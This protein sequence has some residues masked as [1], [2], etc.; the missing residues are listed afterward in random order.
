[1]YHKFKL[2]KNSFINDVSHI[3]I[4]IEYLIKLEIVRNYYGQF[5][6]LTRFE[7]DIN[8]DVDIKNYIKDN[9][10]NINFGKDNVAYTLNTIE[11]LNKF[12]EFF[13]LLKEKYFANSS[14][15]IVDIEKK[16]NLK[17]E[18]RI[19]FKD[20]IDNI[21]LL[22][23]NKPKDILDL[24]I[25]MENIE[26]IFVII[27]KDIYKDEEFNDLINLLIMELING[28][29][30]DIISKV[31][32][33]ENYKKNIFSVFIRYN[34][35][36]KIINVD[37]NKPVISNLNSKNTVK[38]EKLVFFMIK[39]ISI[40][41]FFDINT[42]S[43]KKTL[44][45]IIKFYNMI[46]IKP[47]KDVND[48]DIDSISN[49]KN[50][51]FGTIVEYDIQFIKKIKETLKIERKQNYKIISFKLNSIEYFFKLN[52]TFIILLNDILFNFSQFLKSINNSK[53]FK[54]QLLYYN[55]LIKNIKEFFYIQ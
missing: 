26:I 35:I 44:I 6:Y 19:I 8:N 9:I 1:M 45:Y 14:S 2:S 21:K 41:I 18:Y 32:S 54:E 20:Y 42:K 40:I 22:I 51:I 12:N 55:N 36:I 7:N 4:F 28:T 31:K 23:K 43:L 33:Y 49:Y 13:I 16:I 5:E 37:I 46:K 27:N 24:H 38:Y 48:I 17:E 39:F 11:L 50:N 53:N 34:D 15:K 3:I 29:Y 25:K 52:D 47:I 30:P 10:S